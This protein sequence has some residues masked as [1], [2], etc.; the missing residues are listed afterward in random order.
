MYAE[1]EQTE[2]KSL[3]EHFH[4][5]RVLSIG[6]A[7]SE[8]FAGYLKQQPDCQLENL[9]SISDLNN[10]SQA[11]RF[12]LAFVSHVLERMPK[13]EAEHLIASL[14]DVYSDRVIVVVPVG[15][16][17]FDNVSQWEPTDMLGLGFSKVG[18]FTF[19]DKPVHIYAFDIDNYKTTPD[20]LNNKYWANPELFGKYWW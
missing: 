12:D 1:L 10:L 9:K 2:L 18:E 4:L 17:W 11:P 3:I 16:N 5:Q 20:W 6:P 14:R 15:S 13:V 8:L 7:G 19:Q